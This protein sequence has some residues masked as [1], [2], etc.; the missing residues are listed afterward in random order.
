MVTKESGCKALLNAKPFKF[1]ANFIFTN[2]LGSPGVLQV[3]HRFCS[4]YLLREFR[5][6][7]AT[8]WISAYC[9]RDRQYKPNTLLFG[10]SI[11]FNEY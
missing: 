10:S 5:L 1:S 6:C 3:C 2:C 4:S 11:D 8:D 7:F 9:L